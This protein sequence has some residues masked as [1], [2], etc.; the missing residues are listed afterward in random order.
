VKCLSFAAI[1]L[2]AL[3]SSPALAAPLIPED[4]IKKDDVQAVAKAIREGADVNA[5][6][7]SGASLTALAKAAESDSL[8]VAKLL[9]EKKAD[10]NLSDQRGG[11]ALKQAALNNSTNVAELLLKQKADANAQ[12]KSGYTPLM[13]ASEA[14]FYDVAQLLI[15][16]GATIDGRRNSYGMTALFH[17]IKGRSET[18][19]RL[20]VERGADVNSPMDSD[21]MHSGTTPLMFAAGYK[22]LPIVKLLIEHDANINARNKA[23][24]TALSIA[25]KAEMNG[26]VI[27]YLKEHGAL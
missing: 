20:L 15:D 3:R 16:H 4:A 5:F 21:N 7:P 25:Q 6:Y 1:T 8:K 10:V 2:L 24:D 18:V 11:T 9:I 13:F 12:D 23:G 26:N 19:A 17:A 27:T 14:G 22:S